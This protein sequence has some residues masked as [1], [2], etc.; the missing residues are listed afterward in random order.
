[1]KCAIQQIHNSKT[2]DF[3]HVLRPWILCWKNYRCSKIDVLDRNMSKCAFEAVF[4]DIHTGRF[5]FQVCWYD[6]RP[7]K[8]LLTWTLT[9]LFLSF[10]SDL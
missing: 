3:T 4:F 2:C 10:Q 9:L 1:M 7:N 6:L 5:N 8:G